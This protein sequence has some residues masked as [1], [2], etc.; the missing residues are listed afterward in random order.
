M[1]Q[2]Q[3]KIELWKGISNLTTE[4]LVNNLAQARLQIDRLTAELNQLKQQQD[5]NKPVA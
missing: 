1:N 4:T 5:P 3:I 2:D